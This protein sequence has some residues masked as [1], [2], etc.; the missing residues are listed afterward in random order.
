MSAPTTSRWRRLVVD[1]APLAHLPFRRLWASTVVTSIGAQLTAVAVPKQIFDDTGSSAWVGVSGAV[2][3]V[4]LVVFALWGGSIADAVDRRTMLL[5]TNTGVA[6]TSLGLFVQAAVGSAS[7]WVVLVLLGLQQACFGLNSPA[8][9]AAIPRLVPSTELAAANAL[10]STVFGLGAVAGPLLA[11]ALIPVLGLKVLYLIDTVFLTAAIYACWRL[12]P[13][14]PLL[15]DAGRRTAAGLASIVDGFRYI[16]LHAVLL[17]SF[18]A[19]ITAM[20]FG[21]PRALF[22]EMAERTFGDPPGGGLALGLLYAAIP[23]GTL[24]GGLFSGAFT[25]YRSHGKAVAVAVIAWGLAIAAFGLTSSLWLAVVFLAIGGAA[26]LVSMVFRN[27]MLQTAATDEMRGRMQGVYFVVVA[28]GPRLADLLH[29]T[30]GDAVGPGL[31]TTVGGLL[32]VVVIP[33]VLLRFPAFWR[34][35]LDG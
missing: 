28:G 25:R 32:V 29:G 33:F 26:D 30:V 35:R 14:P 11:G 19:D 1:T 15:N 9:G 10:N 17:V 5:F 12:P 7:V 8:R 18:L 6:L 27:A 13:L 16:S 22:P 31:T 3:L 21:M 4:P 20:V 23:L 24:L 34:Y 2:A